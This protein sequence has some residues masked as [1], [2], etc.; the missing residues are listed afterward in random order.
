MQLI[1]LSTQWHLQ[2][3]PHDITEGRKPLS[4]GRE[5]MSSNGSLAV[6]LETPVAVESDWLA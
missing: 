6:D 3:L 4:P 1:K 2:A 5:L